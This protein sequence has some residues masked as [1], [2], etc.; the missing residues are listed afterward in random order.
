MAQQIISEATRRVNWNIPPGDSEA[1]QASA[2]RDKEVVILGRGFAYPNAREAALKDSR[3]L[4]D[5][6]SGP[7]DC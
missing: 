7:I 6:S 1:V 2:P 4:Q 5:L 3:D